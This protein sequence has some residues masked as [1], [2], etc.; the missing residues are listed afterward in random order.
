VVVGQL[1]PYP[2]EPGCCGYPLDGG[3]LAGADGPAGGL[4]GGGLL[5]GA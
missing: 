2:P 3:G 1:W 5:G 4:A